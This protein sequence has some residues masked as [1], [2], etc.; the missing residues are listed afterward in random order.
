[1]S[2]G[3]SSSRCPP[4]QSHRL[5]VFSRY[6][7]LAVLTALVSLSGLT[8]RPG[9]GQTIRGVLLEQGSGQ[10]IS[11]AFIVVLDEEG[12]RPGQDIGTLT[13]DEGRFRLR[14]P[15]PGRYRLRAERIGFR[16]TLGDV[17]ELAV[18]E[19]VEV[20]LVAPVEAVRLEALAVTGESRCGVRPEAGR[21][22]AEIW[23]EARKALSV[24]DWGAQGILRYRVL[25]WERELTPH[26]LRV[27]KER[28]WPWFWNARGGLFTTRPAEDLAEH[29]YVRPLPADSFVFY[30]PDA[31]VVLS[32]SF[33]DQHCFAVR[34]GRGDHAGLIGLAFEPA[35]GRDLPD[36]EGVLWLDKETAELR[37][38]EYRYKHL[39]LPVWNDDIGGRV[40]FER[41]PSGAWIISHWYIRSPIVE[42][43]TPVHP[44]GDRYRLA[45]VREDGGAVV[46]IRTA[47]GAPVTRWL[48]TRLAGAVFDSTRAEPLAGATVT[49]VGTDRTAET[50]AEGRFAIDGLLEGEYSVSFSHPS[51]D[52]LTFIPDPVEVTLRRDRATDVRLAVPS[53]GSILASLCGDTA[54]HQGT[55][56]VVGVVRDSTASA[57]V[58]GATVSVI[59]DRLVSETRTDGAGSYR[60]CGVPAES[61]VTV[62]AWD[63]TLASNEASLRLASGQIMRR[64]LELSRAR[65]ADDR[66]PAVEARV[67]R[68]QAASTGQPGVVL[69]RVLDNE[70]GEPV[71]T[72]EIRLI[73]E[74]ESL[75]RVTDGEG[76]F[77]FPRV[78]PG[79]YEVVLKHLAY[80]TQ[81][82]SIEVGRGELVSYEA[83]LAMQPIELAP[84]AVTVQRRPVPPRLLGFYD[85]MS[86]GHGYF[87]T[88]EDI[89]LRQ[90]HKIS[91]MIGE[92]PGARVRCPGG[93]CYV[94]F[95][96]YERDPRGACRPAVYVDR[97]YLGK[98]GADP[99]DIVPVDLLLIP[100]EVEAVEVYDS[101][102]SLPAEFGGSNAGCG[103]V[104][105]WTR[106]GG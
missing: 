52:S 100:S 37:D 20:T 19:T 81:S 36:I 7:R 1:M 23:E 47:H 51:L 89:E 42:Y 15:A 13:D 65:A 39:P 102:G 55:G 62:V 97:M 82:D 105:I 66:R 11:G 73:G 17:I 67:T 18:G 8:A 3:C 76:A 78:Q 54:Q 68:G 29:G 101:P 34:E 27:Q 75:V 32:E 80:G 61:P 95:A 10:P 40:E 79:T 5:P 31:S 2:R 57:P 22:T 43:F 86:Q 98:F 93:H 30:A 60:V 104:V 21:E 33:A 72:V 38:L 103:V 49:L 71:E 74:G 9:F 26:S 25:R 53:W 14:V 44:L 64:D 12:E 77:L 4:A 96:R 85:R 94:I 16:S 58:A 92:A 56:A 70:S 24:V 91:Q 35:P 90:P 106:R 50:D 41:L 46:D 28:T 6:A 63:E 45:A 88:R 69:G 83:R 87:I 99:E 48:G 84:L 59:A